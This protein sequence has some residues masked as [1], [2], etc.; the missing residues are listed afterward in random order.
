MGRERLS[1]DRFRSYRI[2][3]EMI[4]AANVAD[5][6]QF[7]QLLYVRAFLI[8]NVK[9]KY[10][11]NI[12]DKIPIFWPFSIFSSV[13][14]PASFPLQKSKLTQNLCIFLVNILY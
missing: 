12:N 7:N 14:M 1:G 3:A 9:F 2:R 4:Y 6:G 8:R 10:I 11:V 13:M 5:S